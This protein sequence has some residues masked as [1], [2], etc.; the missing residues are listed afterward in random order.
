ME[1]KKG[2]TLIELILVILLLSIIALIS[3]PV[4]TGII[5]D[6]KDKSYQQQISGIVNAART[7]MSKYPEKL[8]IEDE[9]GSSC[10]SIVELQ[11]A[12]VLENKDISN[13]SYTK[14]CENDEKCLNE[15]FE[16]VVIVTWSVENNKYNYTYDDSKTVCPN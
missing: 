16:G 9:L 13:P 12:G 4:I 11:K 1:N 7:Y 6:A 3:V 14:D 2:F 8:P 5:K 15:H 10:V